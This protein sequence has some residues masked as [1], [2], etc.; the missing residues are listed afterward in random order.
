MRSRTAFNASPRRSIRR[1][2]KKRLRLWPP[3]LVGLAV[4]IGYHQIRGWLDR[5]Q[6]I[7]VL[8]GSPDREVFAADFAQN[9]PDL[10]IWVSSGSNPEYAEAVFA[11]AGIDPQRIHLDYTAIDT[12]TNF[13]TLVDQFKAQGIDNIYLVTSDFHMRRAKVI[14]TIVLG[15]RGID[16]EPI[17]IPT[18]RPPE[19]IDKAIRDGARA[20]LWVTTGQTG[21]E[22]GEFFSQHFH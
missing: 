18:D 20:I 11:E 13:T 2:G 8:G 1:K 15:S 3:I 14:G 7:L 9:H 21:S 6:A 22:I 5:P 10:P 4:L 17:A 19:A 12:V 16:F